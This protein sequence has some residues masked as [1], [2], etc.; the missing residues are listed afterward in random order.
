M[1]FLVSFV[2]WPFLKTPFN[3]QQRTKKTVLKL[4]NLIGKKLPYLMENM[5]QTSL[6]ESKTNCPFVCFTGTQNREGGL[7]SR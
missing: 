6:V 3:S 1:K 5:F 2:A 7:T 4:W